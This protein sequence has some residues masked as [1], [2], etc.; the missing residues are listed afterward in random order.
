MLSHGAGLS[1]K[2]AGMPLGKMMALLRVFAELGLAKIEKT[3]DDRELVVP[4]P[5]EEKKDLMDSP[6][7]R[8]ICRSD[9]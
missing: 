4:I 2:I 6:T 7:Y 8:T 5:T 1:G 9:Q 3:D